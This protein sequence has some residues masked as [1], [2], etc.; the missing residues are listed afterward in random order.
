VGKQTASA[1]EIAVKVVSGSFTGTGQSGNA[2]AG[3]NAGQN[4]QPP[5]FKDVLNAAIWGTFI[6]TLVLEKSFDGGDTYI[7]ISKDSSGTA[8]SYNAPIALGVY[9]PEHNV[10]Y[11][12]N[13]VAYTSGTVNYRISQ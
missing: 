12:W 5:V 8:N 6:A 10:L 4:P 7:P 3:L 9:E 13:C 11:R 2:N 1:S